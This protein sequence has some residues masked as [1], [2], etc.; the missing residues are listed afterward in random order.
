MTDT[1][2]NILVGGAFVI[3]IALGYYMIS[4]SDSVSLTLDGVS[5]VS[6]DLLAKTQ[7]FIDR[8]ATLQ[9]LSVKTDVLTDSRFTSLYSYT[10]EIPEQSVG[11]SNIFDV[12][13]AVP[14]TRT[15]PIE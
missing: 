11:R 13:A 15:V 8:G 4:Q 6:G 3:L 9:A 14:T 7:V 10:T 5:L 2:K 1:L 12:P